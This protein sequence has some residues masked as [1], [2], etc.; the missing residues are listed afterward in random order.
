MAIKVSYD[1]STTVEKHCDLLKTI[2]DLYS[3]TFL[4]RRDRIKSFE[5]SFNPKV[6][7]HIFEN[8]N[9]FVPEINK[10]QVISVFAGSFGHIIS[11][12]RYIIDG[13]KLILENAAFALKLVNEKIMH[14]EQTDNKIAAEASNIRADAYKKYSEANIS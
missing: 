1:G 14:A 6:F 9:D 2:D 4:M 12:S 5:I 11:G 7:I 8:P 10:L 13:V 3:I